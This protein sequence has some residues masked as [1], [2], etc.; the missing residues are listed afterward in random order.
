MSDVQIV[1]VWGTPDSGK[2]TTCLKMARALEQMGKEVLIIMDDPFCPNL[3]VV[4][5]QPKDAR[6]LGS[7]MALGAITQDDIL[8]SCV[9]ISPHVSVLGY[10]LGDVLFHFPTYTRAR[11]E[12]LLIL[13]RHIVDVV[14]VDCDS[15][16]SKSALSAE[17]VEGADR[18]IRLGECT[19][20]SISAAESSKAYHSARQ[21]F[22]YSNVKAWQDIAVYQTKVLTKHVLPHCK[23]LETQFESVESLKGLSGNTNASYEKALQNL[24]IEVFELCQ[25]TKNT[26][27]KPRAQEAPARSSKPK[28]ALLQTFLQKCNAIWQKITQTG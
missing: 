14:L 5:T 2:T 3:P 24:M 17:A 4:T 12:E 10:L 26:Q 7:L 28:R 22:C 23:E 21:V 16:I 9:P 15:R 19:R 8:A 11:A 20:K 6:S 25:P 27:V 1:A 13:T 18:V